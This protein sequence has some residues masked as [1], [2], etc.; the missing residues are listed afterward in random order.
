MDFLNISPRVEELAAQAEKLV[1]PYFRQIED[2]ANYNSGKVLSA[3]RNNRVSDSIFGGTTGYGYNDAGRETLEAVYAEIFGAEAAIVRVNLVS[4]THAI[5][6]SLFGVV[7]PGQ[8]LVYVTG[9]P[10]DTL[11]GVIGISGDFPGSLKEYGIEYGQ[12]E[13]TPE[14]KPDIQAIREACRDKKVGAVGIQRSRGYSTRDSLSVEEIGEICRAVKAVNPDINIF[15]D[16]CYGEFVEKLEPTQVGADLMAGSLIKNPGGGIAPSGGYIVGRAD[17]VERAAARM[18]APG[19]G[20]ECG[21]TYGQT[22]TMLQGLFIAPKV[23]NGAVKGAILCGKVFELLGFEVSPKAEDLR[24]DI[25]QA[26][27]CGDAKKLIS[28]CKGIQAAAPIDS[29]VSPVPGDMP[30]YEDQVIMAAGAF[31]QGS[32]IELSADAPM[33]EPYIAYFQGG[34]TYEHAKFGVIKAADTLLKNGLLTIE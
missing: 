11:H 4:G 15:V 29:F 20:G 25:V 13:M 10:Y 8:K 27:K 9:A 1:E 17:L 6:C 16:N 2:I 33:R 5:T 3:F 22:R 23:T 30:G 34:L 24:S 7:K 18:T 26:V 14:G 19:I 12:V 21:L 31:V 32:T 28:F